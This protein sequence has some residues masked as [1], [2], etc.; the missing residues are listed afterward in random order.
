MAS[1]IF[2]AL[3]CIAL[4]DDSCDYEV[5][6]I[7]NGTDFAKEDF[8]WQMK[9]SRLEGKPTNMT[10]KAEIMDLEGNVVK[11]YKPW[12]S[13]PIS[14]QKTSSKYSPNLKE[15]TYKIISEINLIQ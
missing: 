3:S 9:A 6:I 1:I 14:R 11:R 13:E 7:V 12:T 15:G 4:A 5:E 10:G 8:Q 2:L